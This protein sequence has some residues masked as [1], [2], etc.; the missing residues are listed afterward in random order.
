M[1][2]RTSSRTKMS[3]GTVELL[4]QVTSVAAVSGYEGPAAALLRRRLAGFTKVEEDRMGNVFFTME[5]AAPRPRIMLPAHL[6]EIGLMVKFVDEK[7]FIRF[8]TL[9]GWWSQVLLAQRVNVITGR[10]ETIPGVVGSKPPHVLTEEERNKVVKIE[11]LF[12]DVGASSKEEAEKT[13]GILPGDPIVPDS[14]FTAMAGGRRFLAKAW[15]DRAGVAVM[16]RVLEALRGKPHP[17]TVVGCGTVQ[18]EVGCRGARTVAGTADSDIVLVLEVGIS[19]DVP[20]IKPEETQGE[21]GKGPML[22]ILD[23]HMI[24]HRALRDFVS[25]TADAARIP[26]QYTSLSRGSTDGGELQHA[27]RGVPAL[28]IGVP[29][30]YVH[31]HHGVIDGGDFENTVRLLVEV[32]RRL[33]AKAFKEIIGKG[34]R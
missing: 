8:W 6:D 1:A 13:L 12:I 10:G 31:A 23:A 33:D 9:G 26:Y 14:S 30:R 5:G 27:G 4:N 19:A 3:E 16:V 25:G 29:C 22:C 15:D 20:G 34:V 17:N 18:E 24:P 32:V 11:D 7:G 2:K 28:Y 21:L